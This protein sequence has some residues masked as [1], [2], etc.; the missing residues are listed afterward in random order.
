MLTSTTS[1]HTRYT[2]VCMY[3]CTFSY[4]DHVHIPSMHVHVYRYN[5]LTRFCLQVIDNFKYVHGRQ[6]PIKAI[7]RQ[8]AYVIRTHWRVG[9]S[10]DEGDS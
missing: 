3:V 1:E 6:G 7:R 5:H 9:K 4:Y 2:H 8:G 10:L